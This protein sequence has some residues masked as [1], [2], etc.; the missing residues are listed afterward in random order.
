M[1]PPS[2]HVVD[3]EVE[4]EID[5]PFRAPRGSMGFSH[6]KRAF[7]RD[8]MDSVESNGSRSPDVVASPSPSVGRSSQKS[9]SPSD[10]GADGENEADGSIKNN[11]NSAVPSVSD[12]EI[13]VLD[14]ELRPALSPSRR[15][16][17]RQYCMVAVS[18]LG[19]AILAGFVRRGI[20]SIL[21]A[22]VSGLFLTQ[23]LSSLGYA[24]V[25]W[26]RLM[27]DLWGACEYRPEGGPFCAA[28]SVIAGSVHRKIAFVCGVV[29]GLFLT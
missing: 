23:L 13:E 7:F 2:S 10:A 1:D 16:I 20:S 29:A 8:L 28:I 22:L 25:Q 11:N 12:S 3:W 6:L 18:A 17:M 26:K 27:K 14:A 9:C 5:L 15:R 19:G 21:R 4:T 24:E